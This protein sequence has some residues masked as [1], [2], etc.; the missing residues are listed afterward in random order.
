MKGSWNEA[1]GHW[2]FTDESGKS[3]VNQWAAVYNPY[4]NTAAGQS[5]F[6]WFRFDGNGTM[7]TG[8]YQEADGNRYYMNPQSDGTKGRM[9][10]GWA[11]IADE[12]GVQRCYYFNPN[13][14][15]Y[16]GKML[17][18]TVIDGSEINAEGCWTV[19][20]VVQTK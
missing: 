13:S 11:W 2:K 16:R 8:W 12:K 1:S 14:D 15:G 7:L 3:Y 5:S 10:T 18:N 19:N 4:A 20:G 6:D 9:V 17:T